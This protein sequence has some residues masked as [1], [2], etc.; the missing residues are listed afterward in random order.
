MIDLTFDAARRIA[1]TRRR[2]E[3]IQAKAR[4]A[5]IRAQLVAMRTQIP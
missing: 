1:D 2:I 5:V 4:A 3:R